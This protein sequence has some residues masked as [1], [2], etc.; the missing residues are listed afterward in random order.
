MKTKKSQI[1]NEDGLTYVFNRE[2]GSYVIII[3]TRMN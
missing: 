2:C 1:K 3:D